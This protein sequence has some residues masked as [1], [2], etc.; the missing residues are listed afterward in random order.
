MKEEELEKAERE[1]VQDFKATIVDGKFTCK[2]I[3]TGE[4]CKNK[5]DN[6]IVG[7]FA[8]IL[9][10][11]VAVVKINDKEWGLFNPATD[12]L[13]SARFPDSMFELGEVFKYHPEEFELLP[14]T[15][16]RIK[17][18]VDDCLKGIAEGVKFLRTK[19]GSKEETEKFAGQI[20]KMVSNKIE[21]E[22]KA[23]ELEDAEKAK[24]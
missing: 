3:K 5:F 22:K 13:F 15:F 17:D 7:H 4:I 18:N 10:G 11:C 1:F 24:I 2:N 23:I 21:K 16:F 19:K 14:T 6:M 8:N 9:G 20:Y 12:S